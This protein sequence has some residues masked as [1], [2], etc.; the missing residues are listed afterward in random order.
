MVS[1][2]AASTVVSIERF[3][4]TTSAKV[5]LLT[6]LFSTL[7]IFCATSIRTSSVSYTWGVTVSSMP[8]SS[9]VTVVNGL[10][11]PSLE[12]VKEPERKGTSWPT[13]IFASVLSNVTMLGVDSRLA[14]SKLARALMTAPKETP[15]ISTFAAATV[16]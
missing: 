6:V 10:F 9:L 16:G 3:E 13:N 1:P 2:E 5:E 15:S 14:F 11:A 7:E 8:T 4:V 12:V